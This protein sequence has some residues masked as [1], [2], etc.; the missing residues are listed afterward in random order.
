[1]SYRNHCTLTCAYF[2]CGSFTGFKSHAERFSIGHGFLSWQ[3]TG[4]EG[5]GEGNDR[6]VN[7]VRYFF[8]KKMVA[9]LRDGIS[10]CF[11]IKIGKKE[12][13]IKSSL[14]TEKVQ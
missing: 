5:R 7:I 10:D 9:A 11:R 13:M 6:M 8:I 1:M 3:H 4:T 14:R 2:I 12:S